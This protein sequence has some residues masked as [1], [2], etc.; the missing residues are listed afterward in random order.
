MASEPSAGAKPQPGEDMGELAKKLNNPAASLISVPLQSNF[1]FGGGPNDDGF[2]YKLNVQP[3]IP[4]GLNEDWKIISRTIVPYIYQEDRIGTGTQSGLGDSTVTLWLSPENDKAGAPIWGFGP[5]V[6]FPTA[7][8]DLLGTEKWGA[9][10]SAIFLRQAHGWTMGFLANHLWSFAGE[11][12]RED[13]SASFLQPFLTY[14]TKTHTTFGMNS[15]YTYDWEVDHS[16]V[17]LNFFV[18]Q[19]VKIGKMPVSFQLGGRYYA[20]KPDEGPDWGLRFAITLV[21]P[22]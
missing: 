4:F 3:V 7:T 22:K 18:T 11:G 12:R 16:M 6:Q 15:E 9:G 14:Q 19:L 21:F 2:Q 17:P 8:D 13:V 10:P 5:I 1:D 20:D